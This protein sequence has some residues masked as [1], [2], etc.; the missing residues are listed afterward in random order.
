MKLPSTGEKG[1]EREPG[2]GQQQSRGQRRPDAETHDHLGGKAERESAHDQVGRQEGE[3][4]LQRVVSEHELEVERGDEEPGEHGGGPED[5]DDIRRC[6]IA[7]PEQAER[8]Q[9]CADPRLDAQENRQKRPGSG[10][11]ADR[12]DRSPA[13]LVA[14]HDR[15]DGKQQR[16][17]HGDR[18]GNVEARRNGLA[19]AGGQQNEAEREHQRCRSG[20]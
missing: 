3:A 12:L 7:L 13:G 14:V 5:A 10:E 4:D 15:V 17:R 16:G 8:H 19:A 20:D 9:R 11:Q 2:G 6:D 1:E 18:A